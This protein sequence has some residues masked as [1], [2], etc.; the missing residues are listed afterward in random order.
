M[1]RL[2]ALHAGSQPPEND[3]E[4]WGAVWAAT[5]LGWLDVAVQLLDCHSS[6][7]LADSGEQRGEPIDVRVCK[8]WSAHAHGM[9]GQA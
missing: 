6:W 9:V 7:I 1:P 2:L 5:A 8:Q 3:P 4:Y